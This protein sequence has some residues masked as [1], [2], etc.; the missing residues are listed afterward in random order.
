MDEEQ[1][2]QLK[3]LGKKNSKEVQRLSIGY[4]DSRE[5]YALEKK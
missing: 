3:D 5:S 1:S 2:K 4:K